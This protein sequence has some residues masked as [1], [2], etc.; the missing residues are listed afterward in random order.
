MRRRDF[1][2]LLGG[3]VA[4]WPFAARA[5][6]PAMPVIGFLDPRSPEMIG[7]DRLRAFR[8]GLRQTGYVEGQNVTIEYRWAHGQDDRLSGLAADLAS[9]Q[10]RVIVAD[11]LNSALAAKAATATIPIVFMMGDDPVKFGLAASYNRPGGNVT[12][13]SFSPPRWTQSASS[14]CAN[15]CQKR[16]CLQCWRT[17]SYGYRDSAG[18]RSCCSYCARITTQHHQRKQPTRDRGSVSDH[19][20][21]SG[22]R[23]PNRL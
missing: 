23:A 20:R 19:G 10:V 1:I 17:Q 21:A 6:Q 15:W 8:Q 11:A 18:R 12:G 22:R 9:R 16:V 13:V 14:C 7:A 3:A 4:A 5:Q 2:T